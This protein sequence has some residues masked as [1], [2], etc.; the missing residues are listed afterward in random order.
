MILQVL[1]NIPDDK[2]RWLQCACGPEQVL[3]MV[4][5]AADE[6]VAGAR[7]PRRRDVCLTVRDDHDTVEVPKCR[8]AEAIEPRQTQQH[9][10]WA[11]A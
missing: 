3:Q 11:R 7:L 2:P 6:S 1:T 4:A 9:V 8:A 5:D 10:P